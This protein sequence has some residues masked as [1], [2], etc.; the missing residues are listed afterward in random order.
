MVY[1]VRLPQGRSAQ[2]AQ[3]DAGQRLRSG[4]R[5]QSARG[6][7]PDGTG[8]WCGPAE[9][10]YSNNAACVG[11]GTLSYGA[12]AWRY[13]EKD[14]RMRFHIRQVRQAA[15]WTIGPSPTRTWSP[16]TRRP[17]GKSASRA[18]IRAT[19]SARRAASRCPCRRLRPEPRARNSGTRRAGGWG[20]IRSISPCC[21]TP[22]LTTGAGACMRC[23]W[24]VGFACEVDAKCGTQNTVIPT[25]LQTGNC[26]L[27]TECMTSQILT[28]ERGRVTGVEYFD[29][30]RPAC[31]AGCRPAWWFPR[32]AIESAR[33]LLN[34]AQPAVSQ[35]PR[36]SLRLGGPQP[37]GPQLYGRFRPHAN[38]SPTTIW[39]RAL[40]SPSAITTTAIPAWR[41]ARCLCNE[42]I[43]LPYQFVGKCCRPD[44]PRWGQAHKD[45]MRQASIAARFAFRAPR[46]R[47]PCSNSRVQVDPR[48]RDH[49]GI[50]VARLSGRGIRTPSKSAGPCAATRRAWLKEAGAVAHVAETGRG[51]GFGRPASGRHLPHGQRSPRLRW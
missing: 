12:M 13:M 35:R 26:E 10:G 47:C 16:I 30:Q 19:F 23:R 38:R 43:R 5:A 37:A 14:F 28:D 46:R 33:L 2:S 9:S 18:T 22:C 50:P 36:Q 32:G 41:A 20:C 49:W 51:R 45:F 7:G 15:R 17:N 3:F 34:S 8:T 27:R 1:G 6:R 4:R 31:E 21:A 24:C 42:F 48:V 44:V 11:G 39:V 29:A 40:P 25:A